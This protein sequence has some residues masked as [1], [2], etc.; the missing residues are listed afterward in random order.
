MTTAEKADNTLT[1]SPEDDKLRLFCLNRLPKEDYQRLRDIGIRWAPKQKCFFAVWSPVR[2]SV[3]LGYALEIEDDTKTAEER[4]EERAERFEGYAENRKK[5]AEQAA[6]GA[7]ALADSIPFGQPILVGHHSEKRAR[8]DA[9]KIDNGMRKAVK[10]WETSDYWQARAEASLKHAERKERPDVRGRRIKKIEAALRKYNRELAVIEKCRGLWNNPEVELTMARAIAITNNLDH[11]S[12]CFTLEKYPRGEGKSLY[13]GRMSLWSALDGGIITPE[14][15]KE[16]S[17]QSKERAFKHWDTWKTHAE[18]RLVYEK[19]MLQES[20]GMVADQNGGLKVG[21][22]INCVWSERFGWSKIIKVNKVTVQIYHKWSDEDR[23]F[24]HN[25]KKTDIRSMKSPEEVEQA[26][27]ENLIYK[28]NELS[29]F[30]VGDVPDTAP[31]EKKEENKEL[32]AI[33]ETLE[34]GGVQVVT[35]SNLFPTPSEIASQMVELAELADGHK[36]LE[37]SAGTGNLLKAIQETGKKIKNIVIEINSKLSMSLADSFPGNDYIHLP[38]DFMEKTSFELF[39]PVDRIIMNPPFEKRSD[40]KHIKH[41]LGMLKTGGKL[42][43]LC[44]GGLAQE[45]TFKDMSDHWERLP[46]G[47]FKSA[48]T[49][50]NVFMM[51]INK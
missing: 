14:Q 22:V 48:G 33:K 43:A 34:S 45:S 15:A 40:I 36:V 19:A 10:M 24:K 50:V 44:A 29:V 28:E 27:E 5:D 23:I 1:Y 30:F 49:N 39:A 31:T 51:V 16:I 42:V 13:E 9:K 26:R 37:P 11:C 35:A 46:E 21:G 8:R 4:A 17:S 41:A 32:N 2:E 12:H 3:M 6:S 25:I 18:N 47:S 7:S 20:G 38:G